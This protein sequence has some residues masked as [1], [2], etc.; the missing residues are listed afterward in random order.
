MSLNSEEHPD[1]VS[2]RELLTGLRG[3]VPEKCDF[4]GQ[5]RNENEMHPE[6]GGDWICIHCINKIPNYPN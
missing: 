6:E 4:C 1:D 3:G 5:I 2:I